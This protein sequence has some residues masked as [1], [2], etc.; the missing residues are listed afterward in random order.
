MSVGVGP[1]SSRFEGARNPRVV[2]VPAG[3]MMSRMTS[4]RF[5]ACSLSLVALVLVGDTPVLAEPALTTQ[6][7]KHVD[8]L[9]S[10][11]MRGRQTGSPEHH[12]A[13]LYVAN[14]MRALAFEPGAGNGSYMQSVDFV[15]RR[16]RESECSLELVFDDRVEKLVLG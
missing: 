2:R 15:S 13:A 5:A 1:Y 16:V 12:R 4:R 7:R 9:S 11:E 3:R 6:W 10:D 8:Y 14:E